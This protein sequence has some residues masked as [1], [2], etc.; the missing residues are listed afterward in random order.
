M[1]YRT[2]IGLCAVTLKS[3]SKRAAKREAGNRE[4]DKRLL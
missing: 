4:Q 2:E 1:Q 3:A